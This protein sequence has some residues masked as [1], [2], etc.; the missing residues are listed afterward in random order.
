MKS[1]PHLHVPSDKTKNIYAV[2][3]DT[4][5]R[6]ADN[7]ITAKYKKVD[8]TALTETNLA[9]KKIATSLK[10][11]DRTEP[12][13]VKPPH[14][15]LKDHKKNFY[16]KPSVRLINPTKSDIGSVSKKI[17]DRILPKIREASPLPLWNRTSEAI[18]W[19]RDLPDKSNTRF[20]QLDIEEYYASISESLLIDAINFARTFSTITEAEQDVILHAHV[21][22]TGNV[23]PPSKSSQKCYES[24][25]RER[26]HCPLLA[27]VTNYGLKSGKNARSGC[28]GA[29]PRHCPL[30]LKQGCPVC[31]Y[32][33]SCFCGDKDTRI[34]PLEK[35]KV[36]TCMNTVTKTMR[37]FCMVGRMFEN[38]KN[39]AFKDV[40]EC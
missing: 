37:N 21:R 15:T 8:D 18:T 7:A 25:S 34:R 28:H 4:Y 24:S 14:F 2:I 13:R 9:G 11:D 16:N 38:E 12:L 31:Y 6:L 39:V 27:V 10:L 20:L 35:C 1:S 36:I 40:I 30:H 22:I 5:N 3:S 23:V 32:H 33:R 29:V 17:L 26:S 19:F